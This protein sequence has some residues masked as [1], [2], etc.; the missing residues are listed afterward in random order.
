MQRIRKMNRRKL[1][2]WIIGLG[3]LGYLVVE[4]GQFVVLGFPDNPPATYEVQWYSPRT[5]EL[6]TRACADCH[7][8]DTEWTWYSYVAPMSVLVIRDV[9]EGREK[10]NVSTGNFEE[11]HEIEEEI[12]EGKMPPAPYLLVHPT[13]DLTD[14]E[15]QELIAGLVATFSIEDERQRDDDD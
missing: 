1:I 8:N 7:S 10:L 13:A 11:A 6:W 4:V 9:N 5:E 12:E 3:I 14:A 2:L 15:K